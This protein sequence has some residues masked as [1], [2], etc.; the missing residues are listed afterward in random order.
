MNDKEKLL[1][2]VYGIT[3]SKKDIYHYNKFH[4]GNLKDALNYAKIHTKKNTKSSPERKPNIHK[5]TG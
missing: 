2:D 3:T 5:T 4:Y 1:M